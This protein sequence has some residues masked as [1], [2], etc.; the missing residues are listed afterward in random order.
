MPNRR[1]TEALYEGLEGPHRNG[2]WEGPASDPERDDGAADSPAGEPTDEPA[3]AGPEPAAPDEE[4]PA[5]TTADGDVLCLP[6]PVWLRWRR[7]F[8]PVLRWPPR[9]PARSPWPPR[10]PRRARRT[11]WPPMPRPRPRAVDRL[12]RLAA[13]ARRVGTLRQRGSGG[14]LPVYRSRLGGRSYRIVARPRG[15]LRSEIVLVRPEAEPSAPESELFPLGGG[16]RTRA[17]AVATT[18]DGYR[19]RLPHAS[20]HTI[21][22]RLA[23]DE[24]RR[25]AGG[26]L[27]GDPAPAVA[28]VVG[29][30]ARRARRAGSLRAPGGDR[31]PIFA[32]SG[33]RILVRPV[34]GREGEIVLL[35][36]EMEEEVLAAQGLR[37]TLRWE[38]PFRFSSRVRALFT[39]LPRAMDLRRD[40]G[41]YIVERADGQPI[42]VGKADVFAKRLGARKEVLRQMA[43]PLAEYRVWLGRA[44]PAAR[45]VLTGLE[46]V[47]LRAIVNRRFPPADRSRA[48]AFRGSSPG[49]SLAPLTNLSPRAPFRLKGAM[50]VRHAGSPPPYLGARTTAA[51]GE[52]FE[53]EGA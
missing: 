8:L 24:V 5:W 44:E 43:V 32:A 53:A 14:R 10:R 45:H 21:L 22:S 11:G 28:A 18:R 25:L 1:F 20:V 16:S 4:P 26:D 51:G 40:G 23:P 33:Y 37:T 42:Y 30:L 2:G 17:E 29:R 3:A 15:G 46:H 41:I 38:G 31:L 13:G 52:W 39:R 7:R 27:G 49:H 9:G 47:V 34:S 19:L 6:V 50:D 35:R 12:A 48:S 36:P